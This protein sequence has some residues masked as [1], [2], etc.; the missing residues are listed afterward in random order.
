MYDGVKVYRVFL[1]CLGLHTSSIFTNAF[2]SADHFSCNE[3]LGKRLKGKIEFGDFSEVEEAKGW[4]HRIYLA[5]FPRSGN[6]WMRYLIEEAT[7]IVTSSVYRDPDPQHLLTPFSWGAYCCER[8]YRGEARYPIDGEPFVVKTHFPVIHISRFDSLP[9]EKTLRIVR[10]PIDSFYS[11]YTWEKSFR[12]EVCAFKIPKKELLRYIRSWR[13]FQEYWDSQENVITIRYEDLCEDPEKYLGMAL[14]AAGYKV[15]QEDVRRAVLK[16]PPM[17]KGL[18]HLH[19]FTEEDLA[20]IQ[21]SLSDLMAPYGY[22]IGL[23]ARF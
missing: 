12:Q 10:H 23:S 2:V 16:Y 9:Y 18:K 8:G 19:H 11:S 13:R 4:K 3:L 15:S 14:E 5:T 22:E 1:L 21:E 17:E 7:G 6:H 20:L